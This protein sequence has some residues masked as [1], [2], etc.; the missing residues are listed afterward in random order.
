MGHLPRPSSS[1]IYFRYSEI[2]VV[3]E[4]VITRFDLYYNSFMILRVRWL[5]LHIKTRYFC[6][7]HY[8]GNF[9]DCIQCKLLSTY[10]IITCIHNR[11]SYYTI[12]IHAWEEGGLGNTS[13]KRCDSLL[14]EWWNISSLA[15]PYKPMDYCGREE[16]YS[17]KASNMQP[18]TYSE[19][20]ST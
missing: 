11:E 18:I 12:L 9:C 17:L 15:V 7:F 5:N 13:F 6:K 14:P 10:K 1:T 20:S 19:R 2:F 16:L 4:L 8:F 3:T